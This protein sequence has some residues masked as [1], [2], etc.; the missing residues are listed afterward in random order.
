MRG[1][2]SQTALHLPLPWQQSAGDGF[3]HTSSH[4]CKNGCRQGRLA[5]KQAAVLA[6]PPTVEGGRREGGIP[7]TQK[8]IR[9]Q[10]RCFLPH[11]MFL[12][13]FLHHFPRAPQSQLGWRGRLK[14][15]QHYYL[16]K[17]SLAV[18]HHFPPPPASLRHSHKEIIKERTSGTGSPRQQPN[19]EA[20]VA[21]VGVATGSVGGRAL[22]ATTE[23]TLPP[24]RRYGLTFHGDVCRPSAS[25]AAREASASQRSPQRRRHHSSG[26][27]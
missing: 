7:Q 3:N 10:Q 16:F 26:C 21:A 17:D 8:V 9:L 24:R 20:E 2:F 4:K 12:S 6:V 13:Y 11:L 5:L 27:S 23:R 18:C 22:G 15:R 19:A 1:G 25:E 14:L